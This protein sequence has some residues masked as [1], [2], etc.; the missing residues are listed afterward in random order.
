[1]AQKQ[2]QSHE[3][4]DPERGKYN[5]ETFPNALFERKK[6][7]KSER[8]NGKF[9]Q[10]NWESNVGPLVMRTSSLTTE[11]TPHIR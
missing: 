10:R 4:A 5:N 3:Q 2:H 1:M 8:R 7:V 11:L 6:T 9:R